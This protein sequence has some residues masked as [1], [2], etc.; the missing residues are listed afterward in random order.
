[1]CGAAGLCPRTCWKRS[2]AVTPRSAAVL[3]LTH[4]TRVQAQA[5]RRLL[6][7]PVFFGMRNWHPFVQETMDEV[8]SVGDRSTGLRVPG[9]PVFG[10]ECRAVYEARQRGCGGCGIVVGH[11][12]SRRAALIEA[13]AER[14]RGLP[15]KV[16]FT[17]HSLPA[18][19]EQYD[20]EARATAAAV[21]ARLGLTDWDFAYQSQG[22]SGGTWLGPTVEACLDRYRG[23]GRTGSRDRADRLRLRPRGGSVRYRHAVPR[24]CGRSGYRADAAGKPE[25]LAHLYP[26]AGRSGAAMLVVLAGGAR[27]PACRVEPLLDAGRRV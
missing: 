14:L 4:W 17:A 23:C 12:L 9:A 11:Q 20:R 22:M 15:G 2:P 16:L 5:L 26:G 25:R 24:V 6:G 10:D 27:T 7:I 8:R 19:N 1:M 18:P 3:R 13:F 21:A